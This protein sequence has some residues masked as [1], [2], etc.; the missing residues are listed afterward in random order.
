[1]GRLLSVS[2]KG[3]EGRGSDDTIAEQLKALSTAEAA[4]AAAAVRV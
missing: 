1:M 2:G 3:G 4:A